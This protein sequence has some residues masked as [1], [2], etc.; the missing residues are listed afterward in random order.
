MRKDIDARQKEIIQRLKNGE[1]RLSLCKELG[2]KYET[3]L[4]R[5]NKWG[6]LDKNQ[7][8]RGIP[9]REAQLTEEVFKN[10]WLKEGT[11]A[12]S[13]Q[14]K[15]RLWKFG[16]KPK[17]CEACG[18]AVISEDGRLPLELDHINGDHWDN[19]LENLQVLC[20]NCH[21]LK[22]GNSGAGRKRV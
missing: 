1:S 18:W 19:R 2:C 9:H 5:L 13:H 14:L 22:P 20:P 11:T 21:A 8:R 15:L 6:V 12:K 3:L 7:S 17:F 16:L 10:R 4:T